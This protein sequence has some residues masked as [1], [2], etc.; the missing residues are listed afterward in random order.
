MMDDPT[1]QTPQD[2][3]TGPTVPEEP[4]EHALRTDDGVTLG[5][6]RYDPPGGAAPVAVTLIHGATAVPQ[7]YY[8]RYARWLAAHGHRV[9]TY[10]YRGIGRSRPES[11]RRFRAT[12]SDWA[13]HDAR[14]AFA[15]QRAQQDELGVPG[16]VV[17]HSFGGQ[18]IGLLDEYRQADG[19]VL[20]ASQMG[21]W[22][23]W[24]VAQ[25]PR[26]ALLWYGLV[27]AATAL[28]GYLPGALGLRTDLPGGVAREWSRWCR[29][30]DYLAGHHA[31]AAP[32]FARFDRPT[33]L[34]TFDDDDY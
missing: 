22:R 29:H 15:W 34:F 8:D 11:L 21:F 3:S 7:D 2:P 27:P 26:L 10:D 31:D 19:V 30:P 16:Y 12:M 23:R 9:L 1:E 28:T 6:R 24:P 13:R 14:A 25:W 4:T 5:A 18:M 33:L 17:G 20:V 32:R